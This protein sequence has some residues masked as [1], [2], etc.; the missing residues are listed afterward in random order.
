MG[1][2]RPQREERAISFQSIWGSGGDFQPDKDYTL[3]D[4]MRLSAVIACINLRAS[5]IAQLP[6]V[7]YQLDAQGLQQAVALQ[8]QLI[9]APSKLPRSFWLRQMSMSRDLYGNAWGAITGRDAAGYAS[10]VEWLNPV[11]VQVVDA[12]SVGRAQVRYNGQPFNLD[13]LLV[14]PGFPVPGQQFGIAPLESSGLIELSS[15]AQEFGSEW[16]ANGAVPSSIIYADQEL[17]AEQASQIRSSITSSWKKRRPAVVGSGLKY[18]S[19]DVNA[20]ESQFLETKRNCAIEICQVFG[21]PPE[22]IGVASSGSSVTYA[23]REQQAQ[24]FLV[25]SI[26]ADLVLI[27]EVL[28]AAVPQPQYVRFNTGALLRSDLQTRY[29]SYA[30]ALT[31]GFLT[32]NEVRE[33]EDRPPLAE[34]GSNDAASARQSAEIIQKLYLGVG[35]VLTADEARVIA[36]RA[37][38]DLGDSGMKASPNA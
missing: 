23:N 7:A 35:I 10:S 38:A 5:T 34:A 19:I 14:V 21:V 16:F 22:K 3:A 29:A 2:F 17:T 31:A 32:I 28:T 33:L 4:A 8:P 36:N 18:E 11:S 37:G 27:Q 20:D 12:S 6:L 26:N 15:R 9:A 1:L 24:Q 13:D 30:T 25:D